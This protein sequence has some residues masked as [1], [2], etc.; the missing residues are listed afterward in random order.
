MNRCPK[1]KLDVLDTNDCANCLQRALRFGEWP[2]HS[3]AMPPSFA[4][5]QGLHLLLVQ[6]MRTNS[7]FSL[8]P[9]HLD[10]SLPKFCS[11]KIPFDIA[12]GNA[13][14]Q[15]NARYERPMYKTSEFSDLFRQG[16]SKTGLGHG[17]VWAIKT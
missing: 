12:G 11:S 1:T 4:T 13:R 15:Y 14:C 5:L 2:L 3:L 16:S 7:E 10:H 17:P 8:D 9:S 6:R